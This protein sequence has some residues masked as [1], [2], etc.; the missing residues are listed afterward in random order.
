[1]LIVDWTRFRTGAHWHRQK[2]ITTMHDLYLQIA[3]SAT[4]HLHF[5]ILFAGT[6][7]LYF[8]YGIRLTP[9]DFANGDYPDPD[10]VALTL[11]FYCIFQIKLN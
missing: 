2:K 11:H 10:T 8:D 9:D 6:W 1:M 3:N 4:S 7:A 5:S